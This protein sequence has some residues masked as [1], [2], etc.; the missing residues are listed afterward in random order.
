MVWGLSCGSVEKVVFVHCGF[1]G[2][3]STAALCCRGGEVMLTR[4]GSWDVGVVRRQPESVRRALL[5]VVSSFCVWALL[6]QTG[7]QYWTAEKTNS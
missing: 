5:R 6:H 2:Q 7:A 3:Y 1:A 4:I